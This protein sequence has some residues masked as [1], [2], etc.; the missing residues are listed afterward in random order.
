MNIEKHTD[1]LSRLQDIIRPLDLAMLVTKTQDLH[2]RS[3]PMLTADVS[4][5]GEIFLFTTLDSELSQELTE[6]NY[7]N[8]SY[9]KSD[10]GSFISVSGI[11][12][13]SKDREAIQDLWRSQF[14]QWIE[15]GLDNR[16]LALLKISLAHA[17]HWSKVDPTDFFHK[18]MSF[19]HG[20]PD[21]AIHET[22]G[23]ASG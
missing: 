5:Y 21:P 16:N 14:A 18:I 20:K 1:D 12:Q 17:E 8:L 2:L 3:R 10:E 6:R 4:K 13:I 7:V 11:A 9:S 22:I 15:G 23:T 19:S